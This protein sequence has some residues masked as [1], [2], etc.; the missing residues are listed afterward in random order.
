MQNGNGNGNAGGI[1]EEIDAYIR[2][3]YPF[4]WIRSPEEQEVVASLTSLAKSSNRG[5]R[6][7]SIVSGF[8]AVDGSAQSGAS[9]PQP[10]LMSVPT[11]AGRAVFIF[12][13]FHPFIDQ[14][15]PANVPI[16]RTIREVG[17]Q[18]RSLS[19]A[20]MKTVIFL[21]PMVKLPTE[22]ESEIVVLDWPR[23]DREKL[24]SVLDDAIGYFKLE[25][26]AVD[27]DAVVSAALGLTVHETSNCLSRSM[28]KTKGLDPELIKNEKKQIIERSGVLQW[29]EPEGDASV[30]GGLDLLKDW[31]AL[32]KKGFT[33]AAREYGL[34]APKGMLIL[35]PPGTGKSLTVKAAGMMW[36]MPVLQVHADK[37][38][39]SF[40]GESEQRLRKVL[41]TAEIIAPSVLFIDEIEKLV[42]GAASS[43][44]VNGGVEANQLGMLLSWMQENKGVFV[45]ATANSIETLPPE[46]LRK[47]R[48]DELWFVDL[49]NAEEREAIFKVHLK[50]RK[51]DPEKFDVAALAKESNRGHSGAEIEAAIVTAMFQAFA[52]DREVTTLDIQEAVTK[53]VTLA[54]TKKEELDAFR[55]KAR[56]RC[57]LASTEISEG[58]ED[59]RFGSLDVM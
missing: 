55:K 16:I 24:G 45:A 44:Q 30:I 7:W 21:S 8:T 38:K 17:K 36:T 28:I 29:V 57:A 25:A 2:A 46:L 32:R 12:R 51:R 15:N 48:F 59:A 37:I 18:L 47:G 4:I 22:L 33:Q 31:L 40:V 13:D 42:A 27:R 49:P 10:D 1:L 6:L 9:D 3:K 56:A 50:K 52:A 43:G 41:D 20:E 23:P 34:D 26:E 53:T 58:A 11:T 39:G 14:Q 35:G 54:E 19:P 5:I